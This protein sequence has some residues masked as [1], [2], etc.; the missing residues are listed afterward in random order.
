VLSIDTNIL[1][2]AYSSAAPQHGAARDFLLRQSARQ[3]VALSEFVLTELYV[4]L[5]NP[6][7]LGRPLSAPE[8]VAAVQAYRA[9][10]HWQV[11]GFPADSRALHD[12]LW[13]RLASSRTGRRAVF[14][15]RLALCLRACGVQEFATANVEDFQGMG[16]ARVWNPLTGD[17]D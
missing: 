9:H 14:D 12:Q 11:V 4:L 2:Y 16:F 10:P 13:S 8:A 3:D 15:L 6:S 7:V 5:R 1:L 17:Q